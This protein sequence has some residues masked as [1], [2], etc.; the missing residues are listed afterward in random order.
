MHDA[1]ETPC[2]ENHRLGPTFLHEEFFY[3]AE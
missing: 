1:K 3:M 2:V